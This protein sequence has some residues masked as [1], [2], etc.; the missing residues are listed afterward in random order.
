MEG[1]HGIARL[2][3]LLKNVETEKQKLGEVADWVRREVVK[4]TARGGEP[5]D[6]LP[7]EERNRVI[8]IARP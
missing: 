2:P 5:T 4:V 6:T 7:A 1:R 3:E 8:G